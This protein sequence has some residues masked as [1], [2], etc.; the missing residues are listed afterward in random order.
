MIRA[1][2]VLFFVVLG[3]IGRAE[4]GAVKVGAL[5]DVCYK[6]ETHDVSLVEF[7]TVKN[8]EKRVVSLNLGGSYARESL[9]IAALFDANGTIHYLAK[10]WPWESFSIGA[11]DFEAGMYVSRQFVMERWNF[12]LCATLFSHKF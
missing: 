5:V 12:E 11:L 3:T 4:P 8:D 10:Y 1:I 9:G 2:I 7:L 6:T